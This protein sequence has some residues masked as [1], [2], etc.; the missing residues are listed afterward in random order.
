[1][2]TFRRLLT[3]RVPLWAL[4]AALPLTSLTRTLWYMQGEDDGRHLDYLL[5]TFPESLPFTLAYLAGA[6]GLA[7]TFRSSSGS[8]SDVLDG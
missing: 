4:V 1:M 7:L 5:F 3:F 6:V 8:R 2:T